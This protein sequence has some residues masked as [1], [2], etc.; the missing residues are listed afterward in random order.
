M[1]PLTFFGPAIIP[2]LIIIAVAYKFYSN[3]RKQ[4]IKDEKKRVAKA[5]NY[6]TLV[7]DYVKKCNANKTNYQL[8]DQYLKL[9]I[10]TCNEATDF[11][12]KQTTISKD[13]V[14]WTNKSAFFSS[15]ALHLQREWNNIKSKRAKVET[16]TTFKVDRTFWKGVLSRGLT[17]S[18]DMNSKDVKVWRRAYKRL[19]SLNH[20]DKGGTDRNMAII[21]KAYKQA[22]EDI[23]FFGNQNW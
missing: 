7:N 4:R 19:C 12:V 11:S 17:K 5:D 1:D 6:I 10:F 16:P 21:N 2:I 20:P 8:A 15:S 23:E 13:V 22:K 18:E 14:Y 3:N 9:A